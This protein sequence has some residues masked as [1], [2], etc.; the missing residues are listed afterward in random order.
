MKR[1]HCESAEGKWPVDATICEFSAP[2]NTYQHIQRPL[3]VSACLALCVSSNISRSG[4]AP[5]AYP[6]AGCV[7]CATTKSEAQVDHTKKKTYSSKRQ[8]EQTEQIP[9]PHTLRLD[10]KEKKKKKKKQ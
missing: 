9:H 1:K 7:G 8:K 5:S 3:T 6:E 10:G 2:M 4:G